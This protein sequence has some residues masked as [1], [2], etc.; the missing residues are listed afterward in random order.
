LGQGRK[1]PCAFSRLVPDESTAIDQQS[2]DYHA[3]A[4]QKLGRRVIDEIGTELE[5]THEVRR[6]ERRVDEQRQSVLVGELGHPRHIEH[7]EPGVT[8]RLAEQQ[9]RG[10]PDR[11][12][13]GI[14]IAR[15]NKSRVDT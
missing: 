14:E 12:T 13:P 8:Q 3:V 11:T 1:L 7:L 6:G 4:R 10:W 9:S 15:I 2:A 5:R